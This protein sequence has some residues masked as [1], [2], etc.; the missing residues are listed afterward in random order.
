MARELREQETCPS[1]D[2]GRRISRIALRKCSI[3][4]LEVRA[5][6][7][8]QYL[9]VGKTGVLKERRTPL[10]HECPVRGRPRHC[11]K[12]TARTARVIRTVRL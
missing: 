6:L 2:A 8:Q 1:L 7:V 9:K 5:V 3:H 11:R 4:N 10:Y 12:D